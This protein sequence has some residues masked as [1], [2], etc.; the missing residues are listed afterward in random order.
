MRKVSYKVK[1]VHLGFNGKPE[2]LGE[3]VEFAVG[4]GNIMPRV[5]EL[6][7]VKSDDEWY[8]GEVVRHVITDENFYQEQGYADL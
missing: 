1:F 5:G 2:R 8:C 7:I 4:V 6:M 3:I